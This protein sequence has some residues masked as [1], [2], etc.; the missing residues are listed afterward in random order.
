M[1]KISQNAVQFGLGDPDVFGD[2]EN[3]WGIE[4]NL[5]WRLAWQRAIAR[6]WIDPTGYGAEL[7]SDPNAALKKVGWDVPAG[8]K[9]KVEDPLQPIAW[10]PNVRNFSWTKEVEVKR[11]GKNHV[12]TKEIAANGWASSPEAPFDRRAAVL[13]A[14]ETT[15][16]LRLPPRPADEA[17][18]ALALAD[19]D[20]LSRAYPFSCAVCC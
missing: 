9:I 8:L 14:L 11:H 3:L 15:I 4:K 7:K 1:P 6:A 19:Y 2:E 12:E 18:A 10:D 13:S 16:I 17:L 20:G 5:D